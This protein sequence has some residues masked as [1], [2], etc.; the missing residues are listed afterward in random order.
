MS[1]N[2]K[3]TKS[4]IAR[5]SVLALTAGG[6]AVF[7]A[8]P[9][10]AEEFDPTNIAPTVTSVTDT[11]AMSPDQ[12]IGDAVY[13]IAA[14]VGDANSLQD[15]NTVT[16]CLY[17]QAQGVSTCGDADH[18]AR[19]T[20][21]MTWTRSTDTFT[22]DATTGGADASNWNLG[23][24]TSAD[25][26]EASNVAANY[27]Y[28]AFTGTNTSMNMLFTF[29]TSEVAKEG[30]NWGV[31]VT[32]D[33]GDTTGTASDTAGY[34]VAHYARVATQRSAVDWNT[35]VAETKTASSNVNA[36]TFIANGGTDLQMSV[37]TY[38]DGT[39]T[40]A[41]AGGSPDDALTADRQFALDVDL[42]DTYNAGAND[43]RLSSSLTDIETA[44]L[45][46]GTTEAGDNSTLH[47]FQF[48]HGG[49]VPRSGTPYTATVLVG[50][51]AD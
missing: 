15:L 43:F 46:A 44:V 29:R 11:L 2:R 25:D 28:S 30:T 36:G 18:D 49:A 10:Q 48:Q 6:M 20:V 14:T 26:S 45:T 13:T 42:D 21:L 39:T 8:S 27:S 35:V 9:S 40:L 19:D 7:A 22:I 38:T 4:V 16:V 31:L 12:A 5:S 23:H 47:G 1:M 37:T 3:K 24:T 51:T 33:D 32:A 41:N 50:V 34:T 17:N